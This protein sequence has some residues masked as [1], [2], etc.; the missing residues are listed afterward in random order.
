M[1]GG[2]VSLVSAYT[3]LQWDFQFYIIRFSY[4]VFA[5]VVFLLTPCRLGSPLCGWSTCSWRGWPCWWGAGCCTC[6][7]PPTQSCAEDTSARTPLWVIDRSPLFVHLFLPFI[8][9]YSVQRNSC[10]ASLRS[11]CSYSM[12][13]PTPKEHKLIW[14]IF[15]HMRETDVVLHNKLKNLWRAT[16]LNRPQPTVWFHSCN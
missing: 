1:D 4:Y 5:C 7:T 14:E 16:D 6:S 10:Y 13:P 15:W 9:S 2:I 12:T 11:L 8:I 3:W